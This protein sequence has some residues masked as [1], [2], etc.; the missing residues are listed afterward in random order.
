LPAPSWIMRNNA[1]DH[2]EKLF[3]VIIKAAP[4]P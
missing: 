4:Q 3:Q 1:V 2:L